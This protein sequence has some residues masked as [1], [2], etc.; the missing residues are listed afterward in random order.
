MKARGDSVDELLCPIGNRS[1]H[2]K[3]VISLFP[4]ICLESGKLLILCQI[5]FVARHDLWAGGKLRVKGN[6]FLIDLLKIRNGIAPFAA[7][8]V[9]DMHQQPAALDM[10]QELMAEADALARPLDEARNIRH[11][12]GLAFAHAHHPQHRRERGEMV[13][14]DDGLCLAND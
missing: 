12:K 3:I 2:L 11:Y 4:D 8:N 13:V 5:A 9:Y 6:Q 1:G 7:G 14:R 10:P